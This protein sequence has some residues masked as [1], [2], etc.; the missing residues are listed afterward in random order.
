MKNKLTYMMGFA[1][2]ILKGLKEQ[3]DQARNPTSALDFDEDNEYFDPFDPDAKSVP[4]PE[5]ELNTCRYRVTVFKNQRGSFT[6]ICG[7][8]AKI[9]SFC[10]EHAEAPIF[11]VENNFGNDEVN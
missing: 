10:E 9:G 3:W 11:S 5:P 8:P 7:K 1:A 6:N 2:G 4:P